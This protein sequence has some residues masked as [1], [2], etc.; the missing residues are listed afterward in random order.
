MNK[1]VTTSILFSRRIFMKG[2]N[3]IKIAQHIL[4]LFVW[5]LLFAIPLL[6]GD[7]QENI[8]WN[9]IF[10]IW[11]EYCLLLVIFM[12][13]RY[14]L[15]PFLFFKNRRLT[16]IV[17]IAG[18]VLI[19]S[20]I[21]YFFQPRGIGAPPE[22]FHPPHPHNHLMNPPEFNP[23]I[24]SHGPAEVVPPYANIIIM[25]ILLVGF[26]S[27]LSF[28]S[29]WIQ[30]EQNK[31]K[32]EKESIKNKMAF[33]Q[34]QISPHFFMNTLNNIHALVDID[35]NEAKNA[36]IKLS[37][38]MDYML[39]GSQIELIPLQKE[40]NFLKSYI[41]LMKLRVTNDIEIKANLQH[42]LPNLKIPP[43]LTISFIENAFKYGISYESSSYI[44]IQLSV[45]ER[46]LLFSVEN[47]VHRPKVEKKSV[48][49]GIK[50]SRNRLDLIYG[51]SYELT[52][53]ESNHRFKVR[54]KIP[55]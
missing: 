46:Y 48:G 34:N 5:L 23:Y 53:G 16:Y 21:L 2:R 9:H 49:I 42:D 44:Y 40:T 37:Q 27:G 22:R 54:L 43:L 13:N 33:L 52:I 39:Y 1:R 30:S 28:F 26:D 10:K 36:I 14:L 4:I 20:C 35:T 11:K 31:L 29:K 50:N 55:V 47:S 7:F 17:S 51:N 38:M 41:E 6:F 19:I 3:N 24:P 45:T 18:I 25:S 15:M 32:A 8:N 12:V